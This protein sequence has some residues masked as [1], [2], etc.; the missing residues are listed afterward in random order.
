MLAHIFRHVSRAPKPAPVEPDAP[1]LPLTAGSESAIDA[2][3][4]QLVAEIRAYAKAHPEH[5][6]PAGQRLLAGQH[7]AYQSITAL[8][9]GAH[10]E[11]DDIY[12]RTGKRRTE[13]KRDVLMAQLTT[14]FIPALLDTSADWAVQQELP[15]PDVRE[16]V[17]QDVDA[18]FDYA[19][20]TADKAVHDA[21]RDQ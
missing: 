4:Y 8:L 15:L 9:V 11:L 6:I 19:L 2:A 1:V 12:G 18:L 7:I 13:R 16:A 14:Y 10:I 20:K 3:A 5:G 17:A 21:T